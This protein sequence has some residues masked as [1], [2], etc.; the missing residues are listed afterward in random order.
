MLGIDASTTVVAY[1][2]NGLSAAVFFWVA[3]LHGF[4]EEQ[5]KIVDGGLDYFISQGMDTV[6]HPDEPDL[7][8][9]LPLDAL[10]PRPELLI[11]MD[12]VPANHFMCLLLFTF[13]HGECMQLWSSY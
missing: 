3:S 10:T 11:T 7:N 8:V 12:E 1:D 13:P 9:D 4:P 2:N 5:I 6:D